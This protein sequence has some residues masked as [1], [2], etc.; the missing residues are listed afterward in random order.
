[1]GVTRVELRFTPETAVRIGTTLS[2][3]YEERLRAGIEHVD[4][5]WHMLGFGSEKAT[6]I[7]AMGI[8]TYRPNMDAH[9]TFDAGQFV[10]I[11]NFNSFAYETIMNAVGDYYG[12]AKI[13]QSVIDDI[14]P[15]YETHMNGECTGALF[16]NLNEAH[17]L[18]SSYRMKIR[19]NRN[20]ED[21]HCSPRTRNTLLERVGDYGLE[22]INDNDAMEATLEE[23]KNSMIAIKSVSID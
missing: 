21:F 17:N 7:Y 11:A 8:W 4:N 20:A 13:W 10:N 3:G 5:N 18:I 12:Y 16:I 1:M 19:I 14:L 9:I 15:V 23:I 6:F 2:Q 22:L